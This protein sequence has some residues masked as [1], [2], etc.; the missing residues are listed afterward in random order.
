MKTTRSKAS[1]SSPY[2]KI[3]E[4]VFDTALPSSK[5]TYGYSFCKWALPEKVMAVFSLLKH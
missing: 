2:V 4:A 5:K 3:S 1:S